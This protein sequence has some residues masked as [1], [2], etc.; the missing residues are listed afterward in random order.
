MLN[1]KLLSLALLV[2]IL[3]T[4]ILTP[5]TAAADDAVAAACVPSMAVK[6]VNAY[7]GLRMRTA[8]G[9]ASPL[10]TFLWNGEQVKVVG[11]DV[12]KDAILWSQVEVNRYGVKTTGW[13]SAA[14]LVS[15]VGYTEPRDSYE[16]AGCKVIDGPLNLRSA[17]GYA[18]KVVRTVPYGTILPYT[19]TPD[20]TVDGLA[21]Q[22][23]TMNG[24]TVYAARKYLEC[25]GA[26]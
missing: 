1:R 4:M 24:S 2:V 10:V 25:F 18:G 7:N 21:W 12:W 5:L 3:L 22:E 15:Y 23:L 17:P 9:L 8:P 6:Y 13:V 26:D 11:C 14:F 19:S 20:V 16:G